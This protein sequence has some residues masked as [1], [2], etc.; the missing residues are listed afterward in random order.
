MSAQV[1]IAG[2]LSRGSVYC[3]QRDRRR[4]SGRCWGVVTANQVNYA[5]HADEALVAL[6]GCR[7]VLALESLYNRH[8]RAVYS[9]ALKMLGDPTAADEIVQE[10][11][12]KLW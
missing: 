2:R 6:L 1:A 9:L 8:S 11:F 10:C 5:D 12:L 7:D 3:P 4:A